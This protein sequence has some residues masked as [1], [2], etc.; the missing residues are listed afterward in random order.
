MSKVDSSDDNLFFSLEE[1]KLD[2]E[3][4]RVGSFKT[5]SS[6]D[7]PEMKVTR[8][9][10]KNR[11]T[12]IT[13]SSGGLLPKSPKVQSIQ[14]LTSEDFSNFADPKLIKINIKGFEKKFFGES[15]SSFRLKVQVYVIDVQV[16][17]DPIDY[18]V[19][20]RKNFSEF[21]AFHQAVSELHLKIVSLL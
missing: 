12:M 15:V 20:S 1:S 13:K 19:E 18:Q 4:L 3:T 16:V 2:G 9:N 7:E 14:T 5:E 11:H 10:L 17:E 21:Q 6:S 8:A